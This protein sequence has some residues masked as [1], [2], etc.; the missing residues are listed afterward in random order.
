MSHS[1]SIPGTLFLIVG[2][3][4]SGKDSLLNGARVALA[5]KSDVIF[6][7]RVITRPASAGGENHRAVDEATFEKMRS[8]KAFALHWDAHDLR[9]GVPAE[10]RGDL[11]Q[12]RKVVV[13]AS[14]G[15]LDTARASFP[16]VQVIS[17]TVPQGILAQR[18]RARGRE[19]EQQIQRRL[20]RAQAFDL[21]GND[22]V[23]LDNGGSLDEAVARF[24]VLLGQ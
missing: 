9:Y 16:K 17:V 22:V 1:E 15:I 10:V 8:D 14:R 21:K 24:V 12:G 4:G 7:R 11:A 2:P 19:N 3:S 6:V 13:N 23:A 20:E 5:D 18:L